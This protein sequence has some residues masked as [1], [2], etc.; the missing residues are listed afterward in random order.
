MTYAQPIDRA[1]HRSTKSANERGI[2]LLGSAGGIR[3]TAK[4]L[5]GLPADFRA[6]IFLAQHLADDSSSELAPLLQSAR[7]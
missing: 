7:G 4:V 3:A 5:G 2:V 6:P 1:G